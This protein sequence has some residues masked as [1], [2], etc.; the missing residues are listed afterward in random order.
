MPA[1][2][3]FH[4]LRSTSTL[5][6]PPS[7]TR[8]DP[9]SVPDRTFPSFSS[10]YALVSDS[11]VAPNLPISPWSLSPVNVLAIFQKRTWPVP[12]V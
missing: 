4:P 1:W 9:L 7:H 5:T 6:R 10:R 2:Q 12:L 8:R 11:S 3:G